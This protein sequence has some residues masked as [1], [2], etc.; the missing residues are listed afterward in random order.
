MLQILPRGGL[1]VLPGPIDDLLPLAAQFGRNLKKIFDPQGFQRDEITK[2]ILSGEFDTTPFALAAA[3]GDSEA[4][5][6]AAISAGLKPDDEKS[7]AFIEAIGA[8]H[9]LTTEQLVAGELRRRPKGIADLTDAILTGARATS[10]EGRL[11]I[12]IAD[13][14]RAA[15]LPRLEAAVKRW[16]SIRQID[17]AKFE[18]GQQHAFMDYI[19]RLPPEEQKRFLF[20]EFAS[21]FLKDMQFREQLTHDEKIADLRAS[22]RAGAGLNDPDLFVKLASATRSTLEK[23]RE[24]AENRDLAAFDVLLADLQYIQEVKQRNFPGAPAV[25][26]EGEE[27]GFVREG[28]EL[29]ASQA[30]PLLY[31]GTYNELLGLALREGITNPNEAI[32]FLG[33]KTPLSWSKIQALGFEAQ[34]RIDFTKNLV[35]PE[36]EPG[37]ERGAGLTPAQ[38]TPEGFVE[39]FKSIDSMIDE[40]FA[41][42]NNFV[43]T[44]GIG[45]IIK[46]AEGGR[47]ASRPGEPPLGA[48]RRNP[49]TATKS[50]PPAPA[51]ISAVAPP[52]PLPPPPPNTG[53]RLEDTAILELERA[54]LSASSTVKEIKDTLRAGIR[55]TVSVDPRSTGGETIDLGPGG[56]V[57]KPFEGTE[58]E[59]SKVAMQLKSLLGR[60]RNGG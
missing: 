59:L 4:T 46:R 22:A 11:T 20:S 40:G 29:I 34:F 21:N 39:G 50:A 48:G 35:E 57:L 36:P 2:G 56:F 24:A 43:E 30:I 45:G 9:P 51:P 23:L 31:R 6:A 26:V 10:A 54:G 27:T 1:T 8:S 32:E 14:T 38:F 44:G 5:R 42:W 47:S 3:A 33:I 13:A 15:N 16:A 25:N 17:F 18:I 28:R 58:E 60:S 19:M 7:A 53:S 52:S 55:D 37:G 12:E 41:I 49:G